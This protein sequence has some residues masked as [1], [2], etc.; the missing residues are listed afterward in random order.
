MQRAAQDENPRDYDGRFAAESGQGFVGFQN[1]GDVKRDDNH[2]GNHVGA[3]PFG[4]EKDQRNN[5]N[6]KEPKLLMTQVCEHKLSPG[7]SAVE[8]KSRGKFC[9]DDYLKGGLSVKNTML[10]HHLQCESRKGTAVLIWFRA[11]FPG[12]RTI[13]ESTNGDRKLAK[14]SVKL[15]RYG[16]HD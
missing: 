6:C 2:H 9:L 15:Y 3:D 4:D 16:N 14:I 8:K 5:K 7:L 1:P 10:L 11:F 12:K 13:H